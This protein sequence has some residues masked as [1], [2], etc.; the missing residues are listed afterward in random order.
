MKFLS[1]VFLAAVLFIAW[2][3]LSGHFTGLLIGLGI[4]SVMLSVYFYMNIVRSNPV[5]DLRFSP[6][7][8]ISY[9]GWLLKE[10]VKANMDVIRAIISGNKIS[11][12]MF[13]VDV[14]RLNQTGKIIYANSITLTPGTVSVSLGKEK[15]QVHG[16]FADAEASFF[17]NEMHDR[18]LNLT[19]TNQ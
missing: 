11:P 3:L 17:N 16:L 14:S 12:S 1:G 7:K 13:T 2:C 9:T 8:L 4:F 5:V 10:I 6:I 19:E 18:V 15:I